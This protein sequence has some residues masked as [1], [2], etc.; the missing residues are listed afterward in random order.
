[1]SSDEVASPF[2]ATSAA[3]PAGSSICNNRTHTVTWSIGNNTLSLQVD[4]NAL[5][6]FPLNGFTPCRDLVSVPLCLGGVR[7]QSLYWHFCSDF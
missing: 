1:M 6:S 7:G 2:I 4:S 5:E 3:V